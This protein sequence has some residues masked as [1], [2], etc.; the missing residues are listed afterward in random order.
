MRIFFLAPYPQGES[1]SQRF[2][3]EHYFPYLEERGFSY[4]FQSFWTGTGWKYLYKKGHSLHKA[5]YLL[6]GFLRRCF[7]LP[8]L[9]KCSFVF[10]HREVAPIGP[11]LFEF[12]IAK[13]LKK[14]IIFDFDDAIW[15]SNTSETNKVA[16]RLKFHHKVEQICKMSWRVSVGNDYLKQYALTFNDHVTVN[17]TVVDTENYHSTQ[18]EHKPK[19]KPIIGWTGTHSTSQYLQLIDQ[20]MIELRNEIHFEWV[21]VSNEPVELKFPDVKF[22][23]WDKKSEI[24]QLLQFDIGIMPLENSEWEKG[25]C[26]FKI[27]QYLSLGMPAVASPVGINKTIIEDDVNGFLANT[28][29][30]WKNFLKRLLLAPELRRKLGKAGRQKIIDQFSV[31]SNLD[32]FFSTFE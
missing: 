22:I 25:K 29:E 8:K 3:F 18:K 11:S 16:A 20:V 2:R 14:K 21:I 17:P 1:P 5:F 6:L 7:V 13:I 30:E 12:I 15:L 28:P 23:K 19:K 26:G 27:I 10:I 32:R 9:L 24:R 31:R 4:Q